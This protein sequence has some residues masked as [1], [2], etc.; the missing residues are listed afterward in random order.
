MALFSF[1]LIKTETPHNKK[2]KKEKIGGGIAAFSSRE[3]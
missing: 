1:E 2:P 3:E